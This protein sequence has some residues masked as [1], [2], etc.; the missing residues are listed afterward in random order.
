MYGWQPQPNVIYVPTPQQA[1]PS[2]DDYAKYLKSELK[3]LR[4]EKDDP[5]KKKEDAK[6]KEAVFGF[7]QHAIFWMAMLPFLGLL[8]I[9]VFC[10][11]IAHAYN[12]L[13]P[14]FH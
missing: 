3:R 12:K 8:Q 4:R 14:V 6:K 13:H 10:E 5:T 1:T 7:G 9:W 2:R 11:V